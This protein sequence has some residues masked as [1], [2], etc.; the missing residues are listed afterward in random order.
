MALAMQMEKRPLNDAVAFDPM[1]QSEW[2]DR[3]LFF[4]YCYWSRGCK[5]WMFCGGVEAAWRIVR[6]DTVIMLLEDE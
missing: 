6:G 3:H 1:V 5:R 4:N 2:N